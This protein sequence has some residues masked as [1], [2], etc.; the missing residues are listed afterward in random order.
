MIPL[1]AGGS[2]VGGS[3]SRSV[4]VTAGDGPLPSPSCRGNGALG[5]ELEEGTC[6][7]LGGRRPSDKREA[8]AAERPA[9]YE[10]MIFFRACGDSSDRVLWTHAETQAALLTL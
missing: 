5:S 6:G 7:R 4:D 3:G 2:V 10:L 8:S 1:G 9:A